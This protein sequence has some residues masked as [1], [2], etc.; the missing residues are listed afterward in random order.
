MS[1]VTVT[2]DVDDKSLKRTLNE[3]ERKVQEGATEGLEDTLEQGEEAA[4]SKLEQE[5]RAYNSPH[6]R[7]SFTTNITGPDSSQTGTIH[8]PLDYAAYV[9]QGVSGTQTKRDTPFSYDSS[10][11]PLDKMIEYVEQRMSSWN[12]DDD[13]P[14]GEGN[15]PLRLGGRG[16]IDDDGGDG[17]SPPGF[18]QPLDNYDLDSGFDKKRISDTDELAED[19][20]IYVDTGAAISKLTIENIDNDGTIEVDGYTDYDEFNINDANYDI[21]GRQSN[22]T[23]HELDTRAEDGEGTEVIIEPEV[24]TYRDSTIYGEIEEELI[25]EETRV[26]RIDPYASNFDGGDVFELDVVN[27]DLVGTRENNP[28]EWFEEVPDYKFANSLESI[29]DSHTRYDVTEENLELARKNDEQILIEWKGNEYLADVQLNNNRTLYE[30][31]AGTT[32]NGEEIEFVYE[33]D[34]QTAYEYDGGRELDFVSLTGVTNKQ[35]NW[36]NLSED[37]DIL[38]EVSGT[39]SFPELTDKL[40]F[41]IDD[42]YA[43]INGRE[44]NQQAYLRGSYTENFRDESYLSVFFRN[45]T[46][47]INYDS[48]IGTRDNNESKWGVKDLSIGDRV[49]GYTDVIGGQKKV[50]GRIKRERRELTSHGGEVRVVDENGR[51]H[52]INDFDVTNTEE[53]D[54]VEEP[55]REP[56]L[57]E[58]YDPYEYDVLDDINL[59]E[60]FYAWLEGEQ[61][62]AKVEKGDGF[63]LVDEDNSP[64][65]YRQENNPY[66]LTLVGKKGYY[67]GIEEYDTVTSYKNT[68]VDDA[69]TLQGVSS[70]YFDTG[71]ETIEAEIEDINRV[72][73]I[74]TVSHVE[75]SNGNTETEINLDAYENQIF[76]IS[77]SNLEPSDIERDYYKELDKYYS[78]TARN[79]LYE[80]RPSTSGGDVEYRPQRIESTDDVFEGLRIAVDY[81]DETK[82]GKVTEI[83]KEKH[84]IKIDAG[85]EGTFIKLADPS[86]DGQI[87]GRKDKI[88]KQE[89]TEGEEIAIYATTDDIFAEKFY[90]TYQQAPDGTHQIKTSN[91]EVREIQTIRYRKQNEPEQ[92][93]DETDEPEPSEVDVDYTEDMNNGDSLTYVGDAAEFDL[94]SEDFSNT[95]AKDYTVDYRWTD[96]SDNP[97]E[98]DYEVGQRVITKIDRFDTEI[99]GSRVVT[100]VGDDYVDFGGDIEDRYHLDG[101]TTNHVEPLGIR[102]VKPLQKLEQGDEILVDSSKFA[103]ASKVSEYDDKKIYAVVDSV[104]ERGNG[105]KVVNYHD[106]NGIHDGEIYESNDDKLFTTRDNYSQYWEFKDKSKSE[107][108]ESRITVK[109]DGGPL[110]DY[111]DDVV[112]GYISTY[113]GLQ[114]EYQLNLDSYDNDIRVT[115]PSKNQNRTTNVKNIREVDTTDT[116]SSPTLSDA[117]NPSFDKL[118]PIDTESQMKMLD[119]GDRVLVYD[120]RNDNLKTVEVD[121]SFTSLNTLNL[122]FS[123]VDKNEDYTKKIPNSNSTVTYRD[124]EYPVEVLAEYPDFNGLE[125]GSTINNGSNKI[126]YG[127]KIEYKDEE[128]GEDFTGVVRDWDE[129][130]VYLSENSSHDK[131]PRLPTYEDTGSGS[132]RVTGGESWSSLSED[133]KREQVRSEVLYRVNKEISTTGSEEAFAD[134]AAEDLY[135][136]LKDKDNVHGVISNLTEFSDSKSGSALASVNNASSTGLAADE[137]RMDIDNDEEELRGT[138]KNTAFHEFTHALIYDNF[139]NGSGDYSR[140]IIGSHDGESFE[141]EYPVVPYTPTGVVDGAKYDTIKNNDYSDRSEAPTAVPIEDLLIKEKDGTPIGNTTMAFDVGGEPKEVDEEKLKTYDYDTDIDGN[142]LFDPNEDSVKLESGDVIKLNDY[143]DEDV[144][145]VFTG[146]TDNTAG[147]F[148]YSVVSAD[149]NTN[150]Y[151]NDNPD[152]VFTGNN[153]F[154]GVAKG[155]EKEEWNIKDE[156]FKP[157]SKEAFNRY[158]ETVNRVTREQLKTY[159]KDYD[160]NG[161]LGI[162]SDRIAVERPYNSSGSTELVTGMAEIILSKNPETAYSLRKIYDTHPTLVETALEV[163][164][165][166]D[167]AED[168]IREEIPELRDKL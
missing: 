47:K 96:L 145:A 77:E 147:R 28:E 139:T 122:K 117:P 15:F 12:L 62:F 37:D 144:Y 53:I 99:I 32:A 100:E 38:V 66:T 107:I 120:K 92:W 101:T 18:Y 80:D 155:V 48:F 30:I 166:T 70:V 68:R 150:L 134:F 160:E 126:W 93:N 168:I 129:K 115:I 140:R 125:E 57:P 121:N 20:S 142:K 85:I 81:G 143:L 158:V 97:K 67:K 161:E 157:D 24:G 3:L 72:R 49:T 98:Y 128:T 105:R 153:E 19:V 11:P 56:T 83:D 40:G 108:K 109:A 137:Y 27:Y 65:Y 114:N 2:V 75:D 7:N 104:E 130:N 44:E 23:I 156:P 90:G 124:D 149:K 131:I 123:E 46:V 6:L 43:T 13:T 132:R 50:T 60:R 71:E 64:S 33:T 69:D 154:I 17:G 111:E 59:D 148:R 14:F 84:T 110:H 42:S 82:Y 86:E 31:D 103:D 74:I 133:D 35:A 119:V 91:G 88:Y 61:R 163:Y 102:D 36:S 94:Q 54:R 16:R 164:N 136:S 167:V 58:A 9:D 76:R 4:I 51:G 87:I 113:S 52:T 73:D 135:D 162:L 79:K 95:D 45:E 78:S 118:N 29:P 39:S 63:K 89:L 112:E 41:D 55:P 127:Q 10:K 26:Y 151:S 159:E 141:H 25:R 34:T 1:D 152:E 165:P 5:R 22:P 106:V 21:I 138:V 116:L 146:R 8:N